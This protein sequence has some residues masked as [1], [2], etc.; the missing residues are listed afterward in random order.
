MIRGMAQA[1]RSRRLGAGALALVLVAAGCSSDEAAPPSDRDCAVVQAD[2]LSDIVGVDVVLR[3]PEDG[4]RECRYSDDDGTVEVF[5]TVDS[6]VEVDLP[7]LILTEPEPIEDLGDLAF[8]ARQ[9]VPLDVR[10]VALVGGSMLTVDLGAPTE[11]RRARLATATEIAKAGL[12]DLP[13]ADP[14]EPTGQRG[15]EACD[16]FSGDAVAELLGGVPTVEPVAPPGSCAIALGSADLEVRVSVLLESG[17]TPAQLES[18]VSAIDT[19]VEVDVDGAPARWVPATGDGTGGQLDVLDDDRIFQVAV[20]ADGMPDAD[21]QQLAVD[22]AAI[23][24][25]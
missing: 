23:A 3:D 14:A 15:D 18:L 6:P 12:D 13:E 11:T 17:A 4:G 21:A 25:A 9:D 5:L 24:I 10:V 2:E 1:G 20:V 19:S 7:E 22:L 16:R 8:A